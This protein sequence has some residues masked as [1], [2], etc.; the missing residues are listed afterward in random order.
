MCAEKEPLDCHRAILVSPALIA[1]G[2]RV[3]HILADGSLEPHEATMERLL[4]QLRLPDQDLFRSKEEIIAE[5]LER[6]GERIAYV[7]KDLELQVAK[8]IP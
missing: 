1:R 5:A 6:Q 4:R 2:L 7:D 8:R 3:E